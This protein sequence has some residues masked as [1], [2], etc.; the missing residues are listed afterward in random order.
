MKIKHLHVR[1]IMRT[2]RKLT[3]HVPIQ[4]VVRTTT[5]VVKHIPISI[6]APIALDAAML[7]FPGST[8]LKVAVVVGK[9]ALKKQRR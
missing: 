2:T 9:A 1:N 4:S 8:A 6:V 3:K 5:K 7:M